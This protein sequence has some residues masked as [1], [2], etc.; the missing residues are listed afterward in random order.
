MRRDMATLARY[1]PSIS[2][3]SDK[4]LHVSFQ[5]SQGG[6]KVRKIC[7]CILIRRIELVL[8]G[9]RLNSFSW[10]DGIGWLPSQNL[11]FTTRSGLGR[12]FHVPNNPVANALSFSA[13]LETQLIGSAQI[14]EL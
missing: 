4:G 11:G 3:W 8:H 1:P 7:T 13:E 10:C 2:H 9:P 14:S 6:S 12:E 5:T